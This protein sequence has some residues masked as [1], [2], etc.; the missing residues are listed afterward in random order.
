MT[1]KEVVQASP[2]HYA[3]VVIGI[4]TQ[5]PSLSYASVDIGI[6]FLC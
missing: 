1:Y 5:A 3:S 4:H 2:P 6:D